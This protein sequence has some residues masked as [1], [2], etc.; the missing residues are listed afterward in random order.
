MDTDEDEE[1]DKKTDVTENAEALALDALAL[2]PDA[3]EPADA[4]AAEPPA[5][6]EELKPPG[7]HCV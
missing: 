6:E 4:E 7:V 1:D 5:A 3:A 2:D